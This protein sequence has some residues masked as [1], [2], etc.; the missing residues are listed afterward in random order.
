M[1]IDG[2]G[3]LGMD[4]RVLEDAELAKLLEARLRAG[5]DKREVA[6]VYKLADQAAKD[7]IAKL[8][9]AD[10]DIVRIGRFRITKK[11]TEPKHVEFD[12]AGGSSLQIKFIEG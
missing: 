8:E 7:A 12:S 9:L 3:Q 6:G 1:A 4:E 10:G 11:V 5:D 2:S